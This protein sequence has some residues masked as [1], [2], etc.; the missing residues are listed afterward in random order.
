MSFRCVSNASGKSW[1]SLPFVRQILAILTIPLVIVLISRA[2]RL[3]FVLFIQSLIYILYVAFFFNAFLVFTVKCYFPYNLPSSYL[4]CRFYYL[5]YFDCI[6]SSIAYLSSI[7]LITVLQTITLILLDIYFP[8]LCHS[9][10]QIVLLLYVCVYCI[11][12]L[13]FYCFQF[14]FIKTVVFIICF[15]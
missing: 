2:F 3:C 7:V 14:L 12:P 8:T 10:L 5:H 13:L 9:F 4:F 1:T 11:H 15:P 6:R